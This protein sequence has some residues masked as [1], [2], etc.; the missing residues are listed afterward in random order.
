[1][2]TDTCLHVR[3]LIEYG[4]DEAGQTYTLKAIEQATGLQHQTLSRLTRCKSRNVRLET[5]RRLCAF[6]G[7]SLDYFACPDEAACRTYLARY[8][9]PRSHLAEIDQQATRLTETG[10]RNVLTVLQWVLRAGRA[11]SR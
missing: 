8:Q 7:I 1:M 4:Q 9:H 6:Y 5:A 2:M 3:V 11:E 10:Q